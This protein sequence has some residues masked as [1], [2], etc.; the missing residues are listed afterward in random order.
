MLCCCYAAVLLP[1]TLYFRQISSTLDSVDR[2]SMQSCPHSEQI[3]RRNVGHS[4]Y[5]GLFSP[6]FVYAILRRRNPFYSYTTGRCV[7]LGQF[8]DAPEEGPFIFF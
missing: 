6:R 7:D 4:F 2:Q 5:V 1:A 8:T 3:S